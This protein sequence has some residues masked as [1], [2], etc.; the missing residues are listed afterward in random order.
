MYHYLGHRNHYRHRLIWL[1]MLGICSKQYM[2]Q[3]AV[4]AVMQPIIECQNWQKCQSLAPYAIQPMHGNGPIYFYMDLYRNG[5]A[6][7][8]PVCV[9]VCLLA[10]LVYPSKPDIVQK[11]QIENKETNQGI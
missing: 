4:G 2:V 5:A 11:M 6:R 1:N 10:Y 8:H 9:F 3:P 7:N